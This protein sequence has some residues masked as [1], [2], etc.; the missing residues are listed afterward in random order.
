MQRDLVERAM[1]GD[2]D[3]FSELA[4]VSVG[5]LLVVARLI[6]QRRAP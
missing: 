3:A 4:R 5:R 6:F 2:H 1:S